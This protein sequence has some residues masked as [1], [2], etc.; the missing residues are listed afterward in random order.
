MPSTE[1]T[2]DA[3]PA[4]LQRD[5][6]VLRLSGALLVDSVPALW[7]PALALLDG[8]RQLDVG[9]VSRV[10]SSGV[11]LLAE[12]AARTGGAHVVGN[13]TGLDA[14]RAAYR[15]TPDLDYAS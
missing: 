10:D 7:K 5:G 9:A 1:S 15:L 4:A 2:A 13:P 3:K 6:A 14:L 12:L 11:A 8:V